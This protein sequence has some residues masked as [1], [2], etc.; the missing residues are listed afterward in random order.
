MMC[1]Q[2]QSGIVALG[3]DS[4]D[5]TG[6]YDGEVTVAFSVAGPSLSWSLSGCRSGETD[7]PQI[8]FP[9]DGSMQYQVA[10]ARS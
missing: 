9:K 4:F 1:T 5:I 2:Q 6:G 8:K 10:Y 7:Y 3:G